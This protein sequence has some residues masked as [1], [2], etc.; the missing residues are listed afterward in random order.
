MRGTV[1]RGW[2]ETVPSGFD[3]SPSLPCPMPALGPLAAIVAAV[4]LSRAYLGVHYPSEVVV[5]VALGLASAWDVVALARRV[6]RRH[7]EDG[8]VTEAGAGAG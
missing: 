5:G 7:R 4:A 8:A 2:R 1:L 6:V 3:A